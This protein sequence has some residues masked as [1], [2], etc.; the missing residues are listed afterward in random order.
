MRALHDGAHEPSGAQ[1]DSCAS[2]ADHALR[3]MVRRDGVA[4]ATNT[5]AGEQH[6][7]IESLRRIEPQ[8]HLVEV[9]L[10]RPQPRVG[11]KRS[12]VPRNQR[13]GM[14]FPRPAL[15]PRARPASVRI[16]RAC[17]QYASSVQYQGVTLSDLSAVAGVS[18]RRVRDAFSEWHGMSPTA[19]LRAAALSEVRRRLVEG[20]F[21][22][23]PVTRAA[24][25]FGFWHLSRFAGQYRALFGESPSETVARA[26]TLAE[27]G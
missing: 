2:Q 4:V 3:A 11:P 12:S 5:G 8:P 24:S 1:D 27:L 22:R 17:V 14:R 21:L 23:D 9:S 18:E 16:V 19:Y 6:D 20:P 26:R 13:I 15:L 10:R 7:G 25:E